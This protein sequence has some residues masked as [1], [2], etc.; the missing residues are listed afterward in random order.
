MFISDEMYLK[1]R[2]AAVEFGG[3]VIGTLGVLH[4]T[5]IK[6]FE[7]TLPAAVLQINIEPFL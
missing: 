1:G 3:E 4:P 2:C 5:V 6:S 7:L